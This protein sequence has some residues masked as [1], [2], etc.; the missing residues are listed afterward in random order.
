MALYVSQAGRVQDQGGQDVEEAGGQGTH[1]IRVVPP[2][3]HCAP[4]SPRVHEECQPQPVD[5]VRSV[6]LGK[7]Q[8]TTH[9]CKAVHLWKAREF[10]RP[11][12]H[13]LT[14]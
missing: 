9:I 6:G 14:H 11:S 8:E 10:P 7:W 2:L 12:P 4:P 13:R 3:P 1:T 5:L